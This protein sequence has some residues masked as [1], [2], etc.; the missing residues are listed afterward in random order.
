MDRSSPL[1]WMS[2]TAPEGALALLIFRIADLTPACFEKRDSIKWSCVLT[3]A[4]LFV[5]VNQEQSLWGPLRFEVRNKECL[6]KLLIDSQLP[7]S[8]ESYRVC[9]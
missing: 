7:F 1:P 3:A 4:T 5:P 2:R 6:H 9:R 8:P